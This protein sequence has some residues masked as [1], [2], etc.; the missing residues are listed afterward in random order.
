MYT[1]DQRNIHSVDEVAN[2]GLTKLREVG[3]SLSLHT[4]LVG[5]FGY[6]PPVGSECFN[7]LKV[8]TAAAPQYFWQSNKKKQTTRSHGWISSKCFHIHVLSMNQA[9]YFKKLENR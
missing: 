6:M 7:Q 5:T 4:R 1:A 3:S 8:V 2:F 9:M